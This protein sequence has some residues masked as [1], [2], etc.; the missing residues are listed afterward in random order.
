MFGGAGR[1]WHGRDVVAALVTPAAA[2]TSD[3]PIYY[4]DP[5]GKPVYSLTPKATADGRAFRP[6]PAS[7]DLNFADAEPAP[8]PAAPVATDGARKIKFY[9]NPM[10]LAD[11]SP[12]PKKDSMGMNYIPVYEGEDHDDGSV[13]LS[14][15][16]I[17]RSGVQSEPAA[18]R[19]LVTKVRAPGSIQLDERRVS[20]IAMRSESFIQSVADVTTGSRVSK[21]EPLMQVYSPTV[22]SAAAEYVSTI[23]SKVTGG[24]P[25]YG[26]GSRQRLVNLDVPEAA[27]AAMENGGP[28]P[29]VL[30][31][32]APRDGIVLERNAIEGMRAQPG[33]VLF[34]VADISVVWALIDVAERD[35]GAL[36][37][38]QSVRVHARGFPGRDFTGK[39]AV[40]Y[41]QFNR[42]TRTA[43][44]RVALANPDFALLPDMYVDAEIDTGDPQPV[45]T[46]PESA[47]L[48]SGDRKVVLVELGAGRYAPRDVKTGHRGG[49]YVEL[50]EGVT[51]GEAVVTAATFLIDAESN[52]N[53]ALKGFTDTGTTP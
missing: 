32:T 49:G 44:I 27:I 29:T 19:V 37:I 46:V 3:E 26:R 6:V 45:L 53:A 36:A 39:V 23:Q 52:L 43:R 51:D 42:D 50:R 30:Q 1:V 24:V 4:Q 17:Q 9:R 11:T 34:R 2:Q 13:T 22:A 5:D 15:Q 12:V 10:G 41:P 7:A 31:W 48:D 8:E 18:M 14:P 28:V 40:I 20:V 33:D 38:G 35:L 25:F 21:G 47:V 16:K